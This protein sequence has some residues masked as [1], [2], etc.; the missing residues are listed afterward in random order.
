MYVTFLY[1][2]SSVT[3]LIDRKFDILPNI[4]NE[5]FI[6]TTSVGELVVAKRVNRNCP[7]IFPNSVTHLN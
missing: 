5:P 2:L 7:I 6:A 4:I 1:Y 3:P